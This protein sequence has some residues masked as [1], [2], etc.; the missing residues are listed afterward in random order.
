MRVISAPGLIGLFS[1]ILSATADAQLDAASEGRVAYG[2][3]HL[4]VTDVAE[5]KRFW[6]DTLGG[7]EVS[8]ADY[9]VVKFANV[10]VFIREGEPTGG[11]KGTTVNHVGF[12]VPKL[13]EVLERVADA[14]Y[15]VVTDQ[16]VPASMPVTDDIAYN[17]TQDAYLSFVMAP[18]DIKIEFIESAGQAEVA[19]LHHI[20]FATQ[21]LD[22][23]QA[24]YAT[25][26]GAVPGMRGNFQAA[27]LP[28]VNLTF[29]ESDQPLS[30]TRG[31]SLDHIGFEVDDLQAFC[32]E[33]ERQG[34][35]FDVPYRE[36]RDVDLSIAFFTDPFGTYIELTEGLDLL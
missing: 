17:E 15:A 20:H 27:D 12:T 5:H 34:I 36:L 33:L 18:D 31:R 28:G 4:A 25:T 30:A 29:S 26:L 16:E 21:A 23:M 8:F 22:E 3:H 11:T 35:V 7:K 13:R 14:G 1:V 9:V 19:K 2:H 32:K 10:I 24:W 6:I